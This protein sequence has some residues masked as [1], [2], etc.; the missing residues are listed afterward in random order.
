[1][2]KNA[3]HANATARAL[4]YALVVALAEAAPDAALLSVNSIQ[5]GLSDVSAARRA[6][7]L[8]TMAAIR[9]PA[10]AQIV[11]LGVKRG[12]ADSSAVV[13]RTAALAVPKC[14]RLDPAAG[15]A[16]VEVVG[17]LLGDRQYYVVG[18]AVAAWWEVCP[19]R[20]DLVHPHYRGLVK[21]ILDM[22]EWGQLA[23]LRMLLVYARKCFPRV[24]AK[25]SKSVKDD[26]PDD[27]KGSEE[28]VIDDPDLELLL[29]SIQPLLQS[30]NS[31]VIVA[32][33][34]C[35][36]YLGDASHVALS[37]GPLLSTL[38]APPDI[39]T[40]TISTI[41]AI[42]QRHPT[43]FVPHAAHFL[44]S[45]ADPLPLATQKLTILS[46][47]FP[48]A[49]PHLRS[50]ML[51][52][53]SHHTRAGASQPL[54]VRAAVDALGRIARRAPEPALRARCLRLLLAHLAS[55]DDALV[56]A[57]LQ[58]IRRLVLRDRRRGGTGKQ[59]E[60]ARTV[61]RLAAHLDGLRAPGARAAAV[62]LVGAVAPRGLA[63][64]VWRVLLR[65]FAKE[66]AEV[67]AQVLLLAA[68]VFLHYQRGGEEGQRDEDGTV[69]R[70]RHMLEH[71]FLLARYARS[72]AL[73]D[74]ARYLRALLLGS[75]NTDLAALLLLADAPVTADAADD[76]DGD[77]GVDGGAHGLGMVGHSSRLLG[78]AVRGA[79]DVPPWTKTLVGG[80]E[81]SR[82]VGAAAG[83][84][85][86]E[87]AVDVV[88]AAAKVEGGGNVGG[89][90]TLDEWLDED[91]GVESEDEDE[92][93]E[94]EEETESETDESE[95]S[96]HDEETALV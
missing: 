31:A 89:G 8:R 92:D 38:R 45:A 55:D 9:V 59:P 1:V 87:R 52:D 50:L 51:T 53:I 80:A 71:T 70:V 93:D 88:P 85:S 78:V 37:V 12:A 62:A 74:R 35:F 81:R 16:L 46:H 91:A 23:T 14:Y 24:T 11:V 32:V 4:V 26:L 75:P 54:L 90:K 65:G 7:A 61:V 96:E 21:K 73:R 39:H 48:N 77:S 66:S 36:F 5:R 41:L 20:L 69:E 29:R 30:R 79:E 43:A 25:H 72:Y 64:D 15:P 63:A 83:E 68:R 76:D 42:V 19:E 17:A 95:E 56:S 49:P 28:A 33:T 13:R 58:Q 82:T 10:I 44:L 57:S 22:D 94:D 67:Q 6:L 2:V 86:V 34:R 40:L 3:S 84:A 60:H 47:L 18:A 27:G